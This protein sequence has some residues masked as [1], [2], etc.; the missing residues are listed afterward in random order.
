MQVLLVFRHRLQRAR[1]KNELPDAE[2]LTTDPDLA[3]VRELACFESFPE[4]R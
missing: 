2:H 1:G 3:S 4:D